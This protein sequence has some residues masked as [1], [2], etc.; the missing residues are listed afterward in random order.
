MARK[1]ILIIADF[2]IFAVESGVSWQ[3]DS[4]VAGAGKS[5]GGWRVLAIA[6]SL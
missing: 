3:V 5:L 6:F 2:M 4:E 1:N